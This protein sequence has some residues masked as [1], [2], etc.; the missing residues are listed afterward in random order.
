MSA[1]LPPIVPETVFSLPIAEA[2]D[3]NK[4]GVEAR[5]LGLGR[6]MITCDASN[7]ASRRVIEANGGDLFETFVDERFGSSEKLRYFAPTSGD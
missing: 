7:M 1:T 4:V 6:V 2:A 3:I 5:R